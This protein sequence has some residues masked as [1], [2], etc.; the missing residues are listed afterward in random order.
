MD[1][2]TREGILA[3]SD[4]QRETVDVPEWKGTVLVQ[5]LTGDER[6]DFEATCVQGRGRKTEVNLRNF[7][8]KLVVRAC[9]DAEGQRL[10]GDDDAPALGR[11]SAA[12]INRVFEVA[13]RL[14]GLTEEDMEELAGNS[15]RGRSGATPSGSP[16]RSA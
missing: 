1:Q 8:A 10:F 3:I 12:A 14:S 2:L 11:K 15:V 5:G 13:A 16:A 4:I 7:R 6:D 9:R